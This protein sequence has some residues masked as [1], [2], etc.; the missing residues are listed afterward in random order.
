[1]PCFFPSM[2]PLSCCPTHTLSALPL[3]GDIRCLSPLPLQLHGA[4][5]HPSHQPC[6]GPLGCHHGTGELCSDARDVVVPGG[7]GRWE[8]HWDKRP[9]CKVR[10]GL[11]Q[12]GFV[13]PASGSLR[14]IR[15]YDDWVTAKEH[16]DLPFKELCQSLGGRHLQRERVNGQTVCCLYQKRWYT[17]W[18]VCWSES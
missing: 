12:G 10:R 3:T 17:V 18:T 4:L 13:R 8:D 7:D 11:V 5:Q 2:L 15:A 14:L 1:M 6:A 9:V 16:Q